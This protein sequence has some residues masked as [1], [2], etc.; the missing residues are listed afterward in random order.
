MIAIICFLAVILM[1][2][3][4]TAAAARRTRSASE[5]YVAGA[6][7]GGVQNGF[8]I[9]GDFMSA[10]TL[11]G[12]T[13]LIFT[14]GFDAVIW[15]AA[16][17]GAFSI[18]LFLMTDKLR[19][20]GRYTFT[21]IVCVRLR[22]GPARVLTAVTTLVFSLMYLM[23]QVVGAGALIEVLFAVPYRWAVLVVSALMVLYVAVG[24]M[25]ATTWVQIIKAAMLLAG[26]LLL[27][28]LS[29]AQFGFSLADLYAA[30]EARHRSEG[31][32]VRAG[33]LSLSVVSAVSL[34]LSI[35]FGLAGSPHLLMRF[36]TV[37]DAAAARQSAGVALAIVAVVNL[38]IF[39]VVGV[40][41]V[42]LIEGNPAYVS[43]GGGLQGG[44]NM[45]SIH[46]AHAVGGE[47]FLGIMAAVAF[48][49]ILAVVAGLTLASVSAVSHDLYARAF[50]RGRAS[51]QAQ[52]RVSRLAALGLG[53]L[54]ALLGILFEGQNIAYL[55]SL[56][57]AIGASTNFPL[58]MFS[59]YW[60]GFT[61]RGALAGGMVGLVSA[62]LL[63]L[64]GPAVWV[65]VLGNARPIFPEAYPALYSMLA[66]VLTM[67]FVSRLD[68]S[69]Q[70]ARDRASFVAMQE[71]RASA[72][73]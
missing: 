26:I 32:L 67:I 9:A 62:V 30:A 20:L 25:L 22:E 60:R 53:V 21:D 4:I 72:A 19:Q 1:T 27:A 59:I 16:P 36:F 12:I 65:G 33:G 64:L 51:E 46:L 2:L 48:A 49:T 50:R 6:R 15:L 14:S 8:A 17:M 61:T 52:L 3:G 55:V 73:D 7:I 54:V 40:A 68:G 42:A 45:V 5:F 18:L 44:S 10:A 41:A 29:L 56:V 63:M 37:P 28:L 57:M 71:A 39:F 35:C 23:V 24:G 38:A 47:V 69:A 13:A 11:L 43:E 31:F 66:A 70:G 58:L 34:S